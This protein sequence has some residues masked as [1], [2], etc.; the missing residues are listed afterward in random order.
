MIKHAFNAL[1]CAL[2]ALHASAAPSPAATQAWVRK[3]VAEHAVAAKPAPVIEASTVWR[4]TN[5]SLRISFSQR[6]NAALRV[7]SSG[8]PKMPAG[9]CFAKTAPNLY[10]N[11]TNANC[12]AITV[13]RRITSLS[14]STNSTPWKT[15]RNWSTYA[16]FAVDGAHY[17]Y[18]GNNSF[19][20]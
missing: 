12:D 2:L 6:T 10:Q 4:G 18:N 7:V 13:A 17:R 11:Y 15:N 3:Y 8:D 9:V 20:A 19:Q 14:V 1:A 16:D 5:V